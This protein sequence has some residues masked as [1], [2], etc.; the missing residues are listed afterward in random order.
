[1]STPIVYDVNVLVDAAPAKGGDPLAW[2][3]LP[4]RT[5]NS[6]ADTIGAVNARRDF[7]LWLSPHIIRNTRRVLIDIRGY[8][9]AE[10]DQY[11]DVLTEIAH[12]SGGGVIDPPRT[13]HVNEDY[14]DNLI[15]DLAAHVN[16]VMIV[17]SDKHLVDMPLWRGTPVLRPRD[18]AARTD[19]AWRSR[20]RSNQPSTTDLIRR[21]MEKEA[22]A[23]LNAHHADAAIAAGT[24][25]SYRN[26]RDEFGRNLD[27]LTEIV[28]GWNRFSTTMQPRIALWEK[29]L[30]VITT[31]VA[32]VDNIA[33]SNPEVAHDALTTLNAKL[34]FALDRMDPRRRAQQPGKARPRFTED[35][36]PRNDL[37]YGS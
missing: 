2:P 16:A 7:A 18:F 9:A 24:P 15:L 19:A 29:N 32:D 1:M 31:R 8:D 20:S 3:S 25:D 12:G 35:R 4:P 28:G 22:A 23:G 14:E 10:V 26:L 36:Q 5:N 13:V 21:R 27:R 11:I 34:D 6:A 33:S 30:A 17:S 37:E